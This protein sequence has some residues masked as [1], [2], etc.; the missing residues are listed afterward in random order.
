MNECGILRMFRWFSGFSVRCWAC[1]KVQ[2]WFPDTHTHTTHT[3]HT[4]THTP[5]T[6]HQHTHTHTHPQHT[7]TTHTHTWLFI[8]Q[9]FSLPEETEQQHISRASLQEFNSSLPP[10]CVCVCVCVLEGYEHKGAG[11]S[12][13]SSTLYR[14]QVRERRIMGIVLLMREIRWRVNTPTNQNDILRLARWLRF[15][16][17]Y[18]S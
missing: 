18:Y 13:A 12:S 6:P 9:C 7:H 16:C 10:V 1:L 15:A 11:V 2:C 4:H 8:W 3:T 17:Y 5:H 14:M